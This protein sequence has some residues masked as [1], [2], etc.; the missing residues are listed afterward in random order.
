MGHETPTILAALADAYRAS[1]AGRTGTASGDFICDYRDL[2][3][4]AEAADGDALVVA[5]H[6]LRVAAA[7]S[8][9]LLTLDTHPR[10]PA[11]VLRVRLARDGGEDWLFGSLDL[12]SPAAQR[13]RMAGSFHSAR[14]LP[15]P[16]D[17]EADWEKWC[18]GLAE[19][20]LNGSLPSPFSR[21]DASWN[22]ELLR[23]LAAVL[24]WPGESLVRFASCVICGDSK[25]LE[26]LATPLVKALRHLS[27]NPAL[28]LESFGILP[29]PRSVLAH[30]PLQL[31]KDAGTVDLALLDAPFQLSAVDLQAARAVSTPAGRCLTVE[32]ETTFHELAKLRSGVLLVR[33]SFP[34]SGVLELLRRIPP[35]LPVFHF[36][37][38]DPAGFDILRDLRERSG[39]PVA[40]LHMD[41][42]D[43]LDSPPLTAQDRAT[44]QRLLGCRGMEDTHETLRRIAAA[45][46]L[47]RFEQESLGRP[48]PDWPFY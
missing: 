4:R 22:E 21:D 27:G 40:P 1:R 32:N 46:R 42:R 23:V 28:D 41:F 45:G 12:E 24:R 44:I 7:G 26:Q 15:V 14:V 20:T 48:S 47:G 34:G 39:R 8:G 25:R 3:R 19:W 6:D 18:T 33:T 11:L 2:L 29:Q 13:R 16:A 10:D 30:G 9:G 5:E 38:S 31:E 43:A 35:E 17:W 37:D 36:G